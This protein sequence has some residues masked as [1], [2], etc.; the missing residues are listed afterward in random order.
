MKESEIREAK[1]RSHSQFRDGG[2]ARSGAPVVQQQN[3]RVLET[4]PMRS[5][6]IVRTSTVGGANRGTSYAQA[7]PRRGAGTA[8]NLFGEPVRQS[9][10]GTSNIGGGYNAGLGTTTNNYVTDNAVRSSHYDAGMSRSPERI[11]GSTVVGSKFIGYQNDPTQDDGR[12][13]TT[14]L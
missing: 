10:Y 4:S 14:T 2:V 5:Q 6:S 13:R 9:A 8:A 11:I 3:A 12:V 7:S 1:R